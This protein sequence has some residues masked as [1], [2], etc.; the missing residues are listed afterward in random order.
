MYLYKPIIII[1]LE[2]NNCQ[3]LHYNRNKIS[4]NNSINY[5]FLSLKLNILIL[6]LGFL[7]FD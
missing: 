3:F 4:Y 6:I 7:F 1:I 5:T 2:N